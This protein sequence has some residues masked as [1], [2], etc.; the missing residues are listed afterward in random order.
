MASPLQRPAQGVVRFYNFLAAR[1]SF[2]DEVLNGLAQPQK[3]LPSRYL[4]DR[5]GCELF[6]RVCELPDYYLARTELAIMRAHAGELA[7]FLGANCQL[8]EFGAG[9]SKRSRILIEEL[10]PPLYV[11]IDTDG[12]SMRATADGLAQQF[13][14]LN[15]IGVCADYAQALMLPEFV[16]V[17]IRNKAVYLPGAILGRFTPEQ[18]IALLKLARRMVG[19]GGALLV[20]V[21]LKKDKALLEAAYDDAQGVTAA[22][23]LNLLARINRELGADFQLRR[24]AHKGCYNEDQGRI[25][26]HIESRAAQLAH[27]GGVRLRFGEGE[28]IRTEISCK[29]SIEEFHAVARRAGFEPGETWTDAANLFSVH[30]TIAV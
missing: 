24:F 29:Y 19:T 21:D 12:E 10:Q 5:R 23:N 25:E 3:S 16:G 22:F 8:I 14:W 26:L 4:Y 13:P 15:T 17:T 18:A 28:A 11:L 6:E 30:A 27:V 1:D 20:G 2:L 7:K 9:S